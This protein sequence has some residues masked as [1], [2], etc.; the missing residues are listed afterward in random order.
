MDVALDYDADPTPEQIMDIDAGETGRD[1]RRRI[2]GQVQAVRRVRRPN[3]PLICE[4]LV[5]P[6]LAKSTFRLPAVEKILREFL[7]LSEAVNDLLSPQINWAPPGYKPTDRLVRRAM[8]RLWAIRT[9][10]DGD[11][12]LH[13][14]S[15]SLWGQ[16]DRTLVLRSLVVEVLQD[17]PSEKRLFRVWREGQQRADA[18]AGDNASFEME[19]DQVVAEWH[20]LVDAAKTPSAYLSSFHAFVLANALRRPI[21]VYGDR[22]VRGKDGEPYAPSDV[23]GVYLPTLLDPDL[24][25]KLPIAVG[26]TCV[27]VGKVGHFTALV[28]VE[29][30]LRHLPLVDEHGDNLPIRYGISPATIAHPDPER[31]AIGDYMITTP[32]YT[33]EDKQ[34]RMAV[35]REAFMTPEADSVRVAMAHAAEAA[36][37]R[38]ARAQEEEI[39]RAL[40]A[41]ENGDGNLPPPPA[42]DDDASN[43]TTAAAAAAG[44][45]G[46]T[47]SNGDSGND[48]GGGGQRTLSP[49]LP[50]PPQGSSNHDSTVRTSTPVAA[51][52]NAAT[53]AA[54]A[55]A[56][57]AAVVARKGLVSRSGSNTTDTSDDPT[58]G[59]FVNNDGVGGG[60]GGGSRRG[61]GAAA[62]GEART[63]RPER[64][65]D[66]DNA[67]KICAR[68]SDE[69]SGDGGVDRSRRRSGSR[70]PQAVAPS[71][72]PVEGAAAATAAE[73]GN[74]ASG[75]HAAPTVPPAIGS[76]LLSAPFGVLS[77]VGAWAT[78]RGRGSIGS[79]ENDAA[80]ATAAGVDSRPTS[81]EGVDEPPPP[82]GGLAGCGDLAAEDES[83]SR[84]A[85]AS[86]GAG[87]RAADRNTR[88]PPDLE[89]DDPANDDPANDDPA[90]DIPAHHGS[91]TGGRSRVRR[92]PSVL[93]PE[94]DGMDLDMPPKSRDYA[95]RESDGE[96][97][98]H[99]K[100]KPECSPAV[101]PDGLNPGQ[102]FGGAADDGLGTGTTDAASAVG[103]GEQ[104]W[105]TSDPSD[106]KITG[107]GRSDVEAATAAGPS[108]RRASAAAALDDAPAAVAGSRVSKGGNDAGGGRDRAAYSFDEMDTAAAAAAAEEEEPYQATVRWRRARS[109]G[110]GDGGAASRRGQPH[111]RGLHGAAATRGGNPWLATAP[112]PTTGEEQAQED[113]V[114]R[115]D[116]NVV[117]ERRYPTSGAGVDASLSP[118]R[119]GKAGEARGRARSRPRAERAWERPEQ[120][121]SSTA[122]YHSRTRLNEGAWGAP[123]EH[124]LESSG[125]VARDGIDTMSLENGSAGRREEGHRRSNSRSGRSGDPSLVYLQQQQTRGMSMSGATATSGREHRGLSLLPPSELPHDSI[126]Y[127]GPPPASV[128][129]RRALR[130]QAASSSSSSS[131]SSSR[132]DGGSAARSASNK[133]FARSAADVMDRFAAGDEWKGRRRRSR[134]GGSSAA[135]EDREEETG[136]FVGGSSSSS[137]GYGVDGRDRSAGAA[138][139]QHRHRR[140]DPDPDWLESEAARSRRLSPSSASSSSYKSAYRSHQRSSTS[141][142]HYR[143]GAGGGV[144]GRRSPSPPPLPAYS[145]SWKSASL[146]R[147]L[148]R[149]AAATTASSSLSSSTAA[150][151]RPLSS[152][153]YLASRLAGAGATAE[154]ASS[155][156]YVPGAVVHGFSS[157]GRLSSTG[158]GGSSVRSSGSVRSSRSSFTLSGSYDG[159][160][161]SSLRRTRAAQE[162]RALEAAGGA[163]AGS[164]AAG[165]SSRS[166]NTYSGA[167]KF[168]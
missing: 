99:G 15:L 157:R 138:G 10:G 28:G 77:A 133:G 153:S 129:A 136:C 93:L 44:S 119:G 70:S 46:G 121:A 118:G 24:C 144:A 47:G 11:C 168:Y 59:S 29:R 158:G 72:P 66:V 149:P 51:A 131:S 12:L 14:V 33:E 3:D 32:Y 162:R 13:S 62:V 111:P 160:T 17:K 165:A 163:G 117:R 84:D 124:P 152:S 127:P 78:G 23:R 68:A 4:L 139:R 147:A 21:L 126:Y 146:S 159:Q 90:K 45:A 55:G 65:S 120:A 167:S 36:F 106:A 2:A 48:N 38:L 64:S 148:E 37:D 110:G 135:Q 71:T 92:P 116:S 112:A 8:A 143:G 52:A 79:V 166:R 108:A 94:D 19:E 164:G 81:G 141:S 74:T 134:G 40:L 18:A 98:A 20:M 87:G 103:G 39:K 97:A 73:E 95:G 83:L 137:S 85:S 125:R 156:S 63:R 22:F 7:P 35:L 61:D 42:A 96:A 123:V 88:R 5:P 26:Y 80:A 145:S 115:L 155:S 89:L 105:R 107:A 54:V 150:G 100:R 114:E 109:A 101:T 67:R 25:Y 34:Y 49:P 53:A 57:T 142:C 140:D 50:P 6:D 31:E 154:A 9:D 102:H 86:Q 75:D 122:R 16:H 41:S 43:G 82:S 69:T 91:A 27:A 132:G 1:I 130:A 151:K 56:N 161:L 104:D 30:E 113:R 128:A 76:R 58:A 60:G